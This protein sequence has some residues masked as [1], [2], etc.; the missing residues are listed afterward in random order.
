L[1]PEI[2]VGMRSV[3]AMDFLSRLE[4]LRGA[5]DSKSRAEAESLSEQL[6]EMIDSLRTISKENASRVEL[7]K[8]APP[9]A[10]FIEDEDEYGFKLGIE[11]AKLM[12]SRLAA[13]KENPLKAPEKMIIHPAHHYRETVDE[14]VP[15]KF[16]SDPQLSEQLRQL[17]EE[18]PLM[19][20]QSN[21]EEVL[22]NLVKERKLDEPEATRAK[23][24]YRYFIQLQKLRGEAMGTNIA[25]GIGH[26]LDRGGEVKHYYVIAGGMHEDIIREKIEKRLGR[27]I[28]VEIH[29]YK[30]PALREAVE[31]AK[32]FIKSA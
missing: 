11:S 1:F 7:M 25:R 26:D 23:T 3:R 20:Y 2:H 22:D 31:E 9:T 21:F 13:Y 4:T 16:V 5:N 18:L 19:L 6:S 12:L 27:L 32:A 17:N 10:I 24:M 8:K 28:R 14:K 29:N 15:I 30:S